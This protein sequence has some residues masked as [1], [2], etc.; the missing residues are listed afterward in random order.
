MIRYYTFSDVPGYQVG[1]VVKPVRANG[2]LSSYRR[3]PSEVRDDARR[4]RSIS[5]SGKSTVTSEKNRY[6]DPG[7]EFKKIKMQADR[8]SSGGMRLRSSN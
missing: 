7:A 3:L 1:G 6:T 8:R 2:G 5:E 4:N